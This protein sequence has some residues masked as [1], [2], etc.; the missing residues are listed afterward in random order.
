MIT[1]F[2][3]RLVAFSLVTDLS[4][5]LSIVLLQE[6]IA[7]SLQV[8]NLLCVHGFIMMILLPAIK[9]ISK[10]TRSSNF[11]PILLKDL[12]LILLSL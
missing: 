10:E 3:C 1:G 9:A 5:I 6:L 4:Y 11:T 2:F 8:T 7:F 12:E